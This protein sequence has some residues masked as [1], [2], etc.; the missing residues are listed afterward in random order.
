MYEEIYLTKYVQEPYV[1]NYKALAE[2]RSKTL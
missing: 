1:A 2:H